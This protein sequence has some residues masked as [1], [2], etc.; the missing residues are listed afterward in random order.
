VTF[1][2]FVFVVNGLMMLLV[3]WML[4]GFHLSGLL[5]AVLASLVSSVAA[6]FASS[7]IGPTGRVEMMVVRNERIG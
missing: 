6:W 4:E 2:L 7:L 3:A 1:G 5:A